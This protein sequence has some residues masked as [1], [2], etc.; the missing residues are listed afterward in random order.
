MEKSKKRISLWLII[1]LVGILISVLFVAFGFY[2]QNDA[3]KINE[4]NAQEA[5]RQSNEKYEKANE[6]YTEIEE[7]LEELKKKY[8]EKQEECSALDMSDPNWFSNSTSCQNQASDI[9]SQ[10]IDLE[11]EQFKLKNDSYVVY[12]KLVE[13]MSYQIFYIIGACIFGVS[14]IA[15]LIIYLVKRKKST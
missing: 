2:K 12:Y 14:A 6:R 8:N 9:N 10:I 3:K 15:S 13:P 4:M 7:E 11:T 1:L 5:Q